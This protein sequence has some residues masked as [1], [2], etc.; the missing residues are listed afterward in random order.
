M[1]TFDPKQDV[2]IVE[3]RL[4]HWSQAGSLAFIT[5]RTWDSIPEPVLNRWLGERCEFLKRHGIDP[6]AADWSRR[7]EELTYAVREEFRNTLAARWNDALDAC[8]G[9]CVLRRPELAKI[10]GDSLIHFDGQRYELTDYVVMPN[11]VHLIAAFFDEEAMLLQCDSWKHYTATRINRALGRRG[12]F[13][14]QDGF[15]HLIRSPEQFAALRQYI[16]DNPQLARLRAGE[17][18]HYSKVLK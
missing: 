1:Q 3:R 2:L 6:D 10:V 9:A 18:V 5:W 17:F 11:H 8:H 15:D 4:P 7:L 12:R 16:A 14:Q 13:W